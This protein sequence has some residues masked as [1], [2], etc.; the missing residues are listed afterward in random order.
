VGGRPASFAWG[1]KQ[2]AAFERTELHV[3]DHAGIVA[4]AML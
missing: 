1:V 4:V 3:I 2:T